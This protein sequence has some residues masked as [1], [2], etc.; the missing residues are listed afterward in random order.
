MLAS[1][2]SSKRTGEEAR[3]KVEG[4]IE[5]EASRMASTLGILAITVRR[6]DTRNHIV[7]NL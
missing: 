2:L 3:D 4:I 7:P 5:A 6:K 1:Q